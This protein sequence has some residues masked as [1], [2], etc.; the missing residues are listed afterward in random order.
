MILILSTAAST[1]QAI[2]ASSANHHTNR[3]LDQVK[4]QATTL[5]MALAREQKLTNQLDD[6]L[7]IASQ[8]LDTATAAIDTML[9]E[10][11][12]TE[13]RYAAQTD[14][15]RQRFL[16]S[17]A[18]LY[19]K[20]IANSP[21]DPGLA[22][23]TAEL[24]IRAGEIEQLLG[25][26]R[27][28]LVDLQ[29]SID[30]LEE[31][32]KPD[33]RNQTLRAYAWRIIAGLHAADDPQ[34]AVLAYQESE[35]IYALL[36]SDV[37]TDASQES[38][39]ENMD[40]QRRFDVA[41]Q[42]G[43]VQQELGALL[44]KTGQKEKAQSKL[45]EARKSLVNID[46]GHAQL[47]IAEIDLLLAEDDPQK[48]SALGDQFHQDS[49]PNHHAIGSESDHMLRMKLLDFYERLSG[50]VAQANGNHAF[51]AGKIIAGW[52]NLLYFYPTAHRLKYKI[53]EYELKRGTIIGWG[54]METVDTH[55][56]LT[57]EFPTA[58]NINLLIGLLNA[59]IQALQ[60][61]LIEKQERPD[62]RKWQP[63]HWDFE[64]RLAADQA[65][66]DYWKQRYKLASKVW[67]GKAV[68]IGGPQSDALRS[69]GLSP[70]GD[71]FAMGHL[72]A[73]A[74]TDP[75][76]VKT[77]IDGYINYLAKFDAKGSYVKHIDASVLFGVFCDR[78]VVDTRSNVLIA[79]DG[80]IAKLNSDLELIW[81]RELGGVT[82]IASDTEGN[83]YAAGAS[84]NN[85]F[86]E[87]KNIPDAADALQEHNPFGYVVKLSADGNVAW[88]WQF[89]G[90]G[91]RETCSALA[92]DT[93]GNVFVSGQSMG[94]TGFGKT[95]KGEEISHMF[96]EYIHSKNSSLKSYKAFI[97]KLDS[98]G[99]PLWVRPMT[100]GPNYIRGIVCPSADHV[101]F[102]LSK[103]GGVDLDPTQ[104]YRDNRDL[105]E[106]GKS[107]YVVTYDRNGQLA[108]FPYAA[109]GLLLR[110]A[111]GMCIDHRGHLFMIGYF[112]N[113]IG[114][115]PD[116]HGV[117]IQ[118]AQL[119]GTVGGRQNGF[120]VELDEKGQYVDSWML[121]APGFVFPQ[122]IS[123]DRSGRIVIAGT[124]PEAL[125][126]PTG[127]ELG[128][129]GGDDG[130]LIIL[131]PR[132][133]K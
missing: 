32:P 106:N 53:A 98:T 65:A 26:T 37:P 102:T 100:K 47:A 56:A 50:K 43:L 61:A 35:K 109:S 124:F 72:N 27:A 118:R 48:L 71:V 91:D 2:R 7:N 127:H 133:T 105:T 38:D 132:N 93:E 64:M 111:T 122:S 85:N 12:Q 11:S 10:V 77:Q 74:W 88:N 54:P 89:Q 113:W 66:L 58:R 8:N 13:L 123:S 130:F 90:T 18:E 60:Q 36:P 20:L 30:L 86:L 70:N 120:I 52:K 21:D 121:T 110:D 63:Y 80:G 9:S 29:K 14:R 5:G 39:A 22:G 1:W 69:A 3:L 76:D 42:S 28:A 17:A 15:I 101:V 57:R 31:V 99:T 126:S 75:N 19:S 108:R 59:E 45:L 115:D 46:D 92:L 116:P 95:A 87:G 25:N 128:S 24:W 83:V 49:R 33:E 41:L 44:Y 103:Y 78:L 16:Y 67:S 34:Q 104:E 51:L 119:Q 97:A 79:G 114:L 73:G 4:S 131:D 96:E 23:S 81:K 62:A 125:I 82:A 6:S 112:W 107:P 94:Q 129:A 68:A 55:R 117:K 40:F 84:T